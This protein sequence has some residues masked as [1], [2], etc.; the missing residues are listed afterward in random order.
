[1]FLPH[2][3]LD[4]DI[5]GDDADHCPPACGGLRVSKSAATRWTATQPDRRGRAM[6]N[7]RHRCLGR[8]KRMPYMRRAAET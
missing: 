2:T 6:G 5:I 4:A 7:W 3:A 8:E 1:M